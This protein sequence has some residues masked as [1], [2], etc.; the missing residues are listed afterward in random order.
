M[1][2]ENIANF[3]NDLEANNMNA[4]NKKFNELIQDRLSI[5]INQEKIK[6]ANSV[7]NQKQN[8]EIV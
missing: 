3:I 5:A 7:Y 4:A 2:H 1:S 8:S 6:I